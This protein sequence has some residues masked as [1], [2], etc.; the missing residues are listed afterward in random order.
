MK[1]T[2]AITSLWIAGAVVAAGGATTAVAMSGGTTGTT[3]LSQTEVQSKLAAAG[4]PSATATRPSAGPRLQFPSDASIRL[5][6]LP[7]SW[8]TAIFSC[9][10]DQIV[11]DVQVLPKGGWRQVGKLEKK[12]IRVDGKLRSAVVATF[13]A[14]SQPDTVAAYFCVGDKTRQ[15]QKFGANWVPSLFGAVTWPI[16]PKTAR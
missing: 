11:V 4:T 12:T 3:V 1:K 5:S 14:K 9:K 7:S 6:L 15:A 2:V 16:V 8:A 10:A 13:A